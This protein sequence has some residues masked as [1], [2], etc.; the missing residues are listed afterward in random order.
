MAT[1][2]KRKEPANSG[3]LSAEEFA[4]LTDAEKLAA[5]QKLQEQNEELAAVKMPRDDDKLPTF[6]VEEDSDN[7]IEAGTYQLPCKK[8]MWDDNTVK[9]GFELIEAAENGSGKEQERAQAILGKL[10]LR[11]SAKILID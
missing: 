3:S 11:G 8:F 10:V 2:K 9:D 4:A 6:E 1:K 5:L 7:D